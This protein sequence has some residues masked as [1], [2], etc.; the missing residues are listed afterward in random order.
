[1]LG[2]W[3]WGGPAARVTAVEVLIELRELLFGQRIWLAFGD[4]GEAHFVFLLVGLEDAVHV[5][6]SA[7]RLG[8]HACLLSGRWVGDI[9]VHVCLLCSDKRV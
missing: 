1:M 6:V 7:K 2:T 5:F 3:E 4:L 8:G 9:D